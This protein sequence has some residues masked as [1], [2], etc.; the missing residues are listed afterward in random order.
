MP[1][2]EGAVSCTHL[3]PTPAPPQLLGLPLSIRPLPAEGG[4]LG[5]ELDCRGYEQGFAPRGRLGCVKG[6]E[7]RASKKSMRGHQ[8]GLWSEIAQSL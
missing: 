7:E 1:T 4:G 3:L 5:Q 8:I 2:R 6:N